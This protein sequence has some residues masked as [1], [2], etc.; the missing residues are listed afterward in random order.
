MIDGIAYLIAIVTSAICVAIHY[1]TL[2]FLGSRTLYH[3]RH[4]VPVWWQD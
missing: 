1:G 2:R 4:G 3:R